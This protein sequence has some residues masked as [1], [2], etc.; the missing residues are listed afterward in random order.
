MAKTLTIQIKSE[1]EALEGFRETFKAVAAGRRVSRRHGVYFT[2]IEAARNLLTPNR[3]ALLRAIRKHRP[4]SIYELAKIAG[5]DL[6]N[7]Q[8]DLRLLERYGLVRMGRGR[9]S[10]KR[11]VKIPRA[12]FNEISLRIAI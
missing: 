3:L 12:V 2:S 5:R 9:S 8:D 10:G 6:K 7:V 11:R 1:G 4:G